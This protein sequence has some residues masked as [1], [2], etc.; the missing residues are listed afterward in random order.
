MKSWVGRRTSGK[1]SGGGSDRIK[2]A[3][4]L[5]M[6]RRSYWPI[7]SGVTESRRQLKA[8]TRRR[9]VSLPSSIPEIV[10][11]QFFPQGRNDAAE[12]ISERPEARVW[13]DGWSRYHDLGFVRT[14]EKAARRRSKQGGT[15]VIEIY[16]PWSHISVASGTF[17][18]VKFNR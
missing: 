8:G 3:E 6:R 17:F 1:R 13:N 10:F 14:S 16:R 12:W 15:A 5:K 11:L 9:S 2:W 4:Y 18:I 7:L